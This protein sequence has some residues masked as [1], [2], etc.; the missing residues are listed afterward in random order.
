MSVEHRVSSHLGIDVAAYDAQIRRFIP[1]YEEMIGNVVAILGDVLPAAPVVVDL[2]AGTGALAGAILEGVARAN[3]ELVDI[4]PAMLEV[5]RGRL[6]RFGARVSF[7][8]AAFAEPLPACDAV[9]AS[10]ALHHIADIDAKRAA[11][12][13][14]HAALRPGG[15]LLVADAT[16]HPDGLEHAR[17]YRQWRAG[18]AEAAIGDAEATARS[19]SGLSRTATSRSRPSSRCSPTPAS[20]RPTA[21]GSAAR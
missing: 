2:G 12:R 7:R 14:I 3:V 11:Y 9:V 6:A 1:A 16:V 21:S 10:L 13:A 4:D 5:A 18:M 15:A 17:I 20:P 8:R 19:R